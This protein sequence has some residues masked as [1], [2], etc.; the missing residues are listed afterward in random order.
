VPQTTVTFAD[1]GGAGGV[2]GNHD[3]WHYVNG[4][5]AADASADPSVQEQIASLHESG[6]LASGDGP[7]ATVTSQVLQ[8]VREP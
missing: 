6:F 8:I 1:D 2:V 5:A 3:Y 4:A 7:E